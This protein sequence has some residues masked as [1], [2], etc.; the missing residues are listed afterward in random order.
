MELKDEKHD[1]DKKIEAL[2]AK[3]PGTAGQVRVLDTAYRLWD[4]ELNRLYK[5]LSARLPASGKRR[6][7]TTQRLW[8][9]WRD[10]EL[11]LIDEVY[12]RTDGAQ[13]HLVLRKG[14][15]VDVLRTRALALQ[16]LLRVGHEIA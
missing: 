7:Q 13:M 2:L 5:Q 3:E 11:K 12:A 15:R 6:L 1:I 9:A 10:S 14:L 4:D 16:T 8:L